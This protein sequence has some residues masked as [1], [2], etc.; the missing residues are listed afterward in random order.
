VILTLLVALASTTD[1]T[2]TVYVDANGNARRD[3]G[4]RGLPGVA[5]SDQVA[6]V[7]TDASGAFRIPGSQ[8]LGVVFVSLP[9]GYRSV[10]PFWRSVGAEPVEFGLR[11]AAPQASFT[12][13]HASDTHISPQTVGRTRRLKELVDSIK[14]GFVLITGD[15]VRDALRVGEAE[16][17]GYYQL[18]QQETAAFPAPLWTVPGNHE[19]F[20]IERS[21]SGVSATHPLY[22][23]KM[24]H[25]YRG[26][27]YYSFNAGGIHFVGLNTIDIDD[28][29]YYGHVDSV[30]LAWLR[31]DL[32]QLP[33]TTPVVTFNHIPFFTAVETINGFD[34]GPPAPSSIVVG[35]Q[36]SFRHAVSN[37][38]SV[39]AQIAPHPYPLAL[40][41]HMHV[42][43]QL[44]YAGVATRFEQSAATV[45]TSR[46]AG[47][48]FP[49]GVT[50]YRVRNGK[51][52]QGVFVPLDP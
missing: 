52:G 40:G 43:E 23:R 50:V 8:G 1:I 20:G 3:P 5:V 18:F 26:P 13:V 47:L 22:G 38:A 36:T 2:G 27:D 4:E 25:L 37:A 24:Y 46:S 49:S 21:K 44:T 41:G 32:A 35:G 10:G 42:H 16:A 30:Q 17:T 29:S 28:S 31:D 15:L 39:L 9:N 19:V 48:V 11:A 12:F 51:I 14:P 6:V 45:A 33:A 7:T 34:P